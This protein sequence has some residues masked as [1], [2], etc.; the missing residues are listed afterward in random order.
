MK[1][2][3]DK[4]PKMERYPAYTHHSTDLAIVLPFYHASANKEWFPSALFNSSLW[5]AN[6]LIKNSDVV[7]RGIPIFFF[8]EDTLAP[9]CLSFFRDAGVPDANLIQFTA[10]NPNPRVKRMR[11]SKAFYMLEHEALTTYKVLSRFDADLFLCR[12]PRI[13]ESFKIDVLASVAPDSG[14][15][16]MWWNDTKLVDYQGKRWWWAKNNASVNHNFRECV[17]IMKRFLGDADFTGKIF[18]TMSGGV[19][20]FEL[21]RIPGF[22]D[23][24][25]EYEPLLGDEELL[26]WM[27]AKKHGYIYPSLIDP[28]AWAFDGRHDSVVGMHEGGEPF[29][30]SHCYEPPRPNR[31]V[32]S[33]WYQAAGIGD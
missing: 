26:L 14:I 22:L 5:V 21:G 17:P 32:L 6:S 30:W 19:E 1:S 8:I 15:G 25:K 9:E 23:F 28:C 3:L 29:Y 12:L 10:P 2:Y 13:S 16:V 11:I 20:S 7:K 4:L 31:K 27:W 24:I 18:P 33:M